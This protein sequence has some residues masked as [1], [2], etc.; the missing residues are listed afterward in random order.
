M[1][2]LPRSG[3]SEE[4]NGSVKIDPGFRNAPGLSL[5]ETPTVFLTFTSQVFIT[6]MPGLENH[7]AYTPVSDKRRRTLQFDCA[8]CQAHV[9]IH[10]QGVSALSSGL[11]SSWSDGGGSFGMSSQSPF[12]AGTSSA[13]AAAAAPSSCQRAATWSTRGRKQA[14]W[15]FP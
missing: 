1:L 12:E 6:W 14:D 9:Q 7:I 3:L 11:R 13:A 8:G 15:D 10:V 2:F 4:Q 5:L